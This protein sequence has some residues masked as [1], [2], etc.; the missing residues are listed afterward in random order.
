MFQPFFHFSPLGL[1]ALLT[2][3]VDKFVST[4][5]N[6]RFERI[7]HMTSPRVCYYGSHWTQLQ[8][9]VQHWTAYYTTK[10]RKLIILTCR[11]IIPPYLG[12][13]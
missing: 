13:F 10:H 4:F 2:K 12:Y 3:H 11:T 6:L 5:L 1:Y 8:Q 7:Q 9:I